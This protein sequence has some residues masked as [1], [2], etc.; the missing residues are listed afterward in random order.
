[1]IKK[2]LVLA[3]SIAAF[4]AVVMV[5]SAALAHSNSTFVPGPCPTGV[6]H[7]DTCVYKC[8]AGVTN[9][10]YCVAYQCP[11]GVTNPAYCTKISPSPSIIELSPV[12]DIAVVKGQ[13]AVGLSCFGKAACI[14]KLTI[15]GPGYYHHGIYHPGKIL[16]TATYDV[17]G[18]SVGMAD[19]ALSG[20]YR[21]VYIT[22]VDY[23]GPHDQGHFKLYYFSF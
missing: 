11:P 12:P 20:T 17:K 15:Y 18:N 22:A 2:T 19:F 1:M 4:A 21:Q 7:K 23:A 3:V 6:P 10:S 14:G 8:P 16:A 9:L 5:P 13:G